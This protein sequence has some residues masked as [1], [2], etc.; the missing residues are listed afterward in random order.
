MSSTSMM[1]PPNSASGT[2]TDSS[3]RRLSECT[4]ANQPC[5]PLYGVASRGTAKR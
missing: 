1:M 3:S 5:R 2:E 4:D